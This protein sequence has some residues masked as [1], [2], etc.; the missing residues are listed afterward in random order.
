MTGCTPK[1]TALSLELVDYARGVALKEAKQRSPNFVIRED[2]RGTFEQSA[3]Q[4]AT[5]GHLLKRFTHWSLQ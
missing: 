3:S 2:V 5:F 4:I 1:E